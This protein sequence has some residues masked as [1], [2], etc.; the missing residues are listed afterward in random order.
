MSLTQGSGPLG[1][2]AG[3]TNYT[4]EAP[5]HRILFQ[6]DGRRLRALVAGRVVLDKIGRA[7]V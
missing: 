6:P 1:R 3:E 7:H 4:I 5:A 2:G